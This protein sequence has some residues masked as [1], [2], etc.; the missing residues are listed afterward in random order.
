MGGKGGVYGV[1]MGWVGGRMMGSR[2]AEVGS[3]KG[4]LGVKHEVPVSE[5]RSP[6]HQ[7]SQQQRPYRFGN[8][9][10]LKHSFGCTFLLHAC[11]C[12]FRHSGAED[13]TISQ[14]SARI[15]LI[16]SSAS[17]SLRAGSPAGLRAATF[18]HDVIF[19]ETRTPKTHPGTSNEQCASPLL[20]R[21]ARHLP[22]LIRPR[23]QMSNAGETSQPTPKKSGLSKFKLAVNVV[24]KSQNFV[25]KLRSCRTSE[26]LQESYNTVSEL[27]AGTPYVPPQSQIRAR[28]RTCQRAILKCPAQCR[29]IPSSLKHRRAD[30]SLCETSRRRSD[31]AIFNKFTTAAPADDPAKNAH[32]SRIR[33][34]RAAKMRV[35]TSLNGFFSIEAKMQ[36]QTA[37]GP[38]VPCAVGTT[39]ALCDTESVEI[40][41]VETRDPADEALLLGCSSRLAA[42]KAD[43]DA[44]DLTRET[45]GIPALLSAFQQLCLTRAVPRHSRLRSSI[46]QELGL[47]VRA[48]VPLRLCTSY[49]RTCLCV[50]V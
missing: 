47:Q 19:G 6:P 46:L 32:I 26:L 27:C 22:A 35:F 25:S 2:S 10:F 11:N 7:E 23:Q 4:G 39:D 1:H 30:E 14:Y 24:A 28:A 41:D 18:F 42:I 12:G 13:D 40:P 20:G 33:R 49:T 8:Q 50:L 17:C 9:F 31:A 21:P 5:A 43:V 16:R 3:R 37:Q 15:T 36:E 29:T 34:E 38:V 48:R 45:A 44:S